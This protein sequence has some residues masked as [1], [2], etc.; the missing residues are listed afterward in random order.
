MFIEIS[1]RFQQT[2]LVVSE[3]GNNLATTGLQELDDTVQTFF[4]LVPP[5]DVITQKYHLVFRLCIGNQPGN[6]FV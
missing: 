4:G 2:R 6:Q 3:Q 1:E 5:V